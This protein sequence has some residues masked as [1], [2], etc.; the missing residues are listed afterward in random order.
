MIEFLAPAWMLG[1]LAAAVPLLIHLMRRRIGTQVEF[2]AVRYLVRAEREHSRKLR[3]RNL[4]L[5]ILRVLAVLFV[6]GAAARPVARVGSGGH[7]PTSMAIVLDNSLSSS[8]IQAGHPVLDDLKTRAR[9]VLR[10]A[11]ADDHI[12][13]IT[14]DGVVH[15]GSVGA[16]MQAIDRVE[17]FGGAGDL[18]RA[19]ARASGLVRAGVLNEREI[20]IITDGQATSWKTPVSIGDAKVLVYR[21]KGAPPPNHGVIEATASPSRWTPRGAVQARV[22][23]ADSATYRITLEGRTLARGSVARDGEILVRASPPERGWVSGTVEVEPDELRGDDVRPFA[24][25]IGPAPSVNV[26]PSLG[27]FA[28][29]AVDALVQSERVTAGGDVAFAPADEVSKL[30]A[31]I[32]AP[33]D[34][35]RV[36]AANRALE[37]LGIP[38]RFGAI[39]RSESVVRGDRLDNATVTLRYVLSSSGG[40]Q[41]DTL[42]TAAG[43]PWIVSGPGY[44]LIASPL[45]PDATTL[46]VR[47]GFVPWLSDVLSQRLSAES[48]TVMQTVPGAALSRP[49]FADALEAA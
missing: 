14:V 35:I 16:V 18:A 25:W 3:L 46:P 48:G 49:A 32:V 5:M 28:R 31:L 23:V 7:A 10:R 9:D 29:S 47:A 21:P 43:E 2:P 42:A 4:L 38:W 1:A 8:V 37:R 6:A 40:R 20:A 36:G 27:M 39:R 45:T 34:P 12:W 22:L 13:L 17:A 30:P 26:A 11:S 33:S 19:L 15:G 24:A 44:V 41:I